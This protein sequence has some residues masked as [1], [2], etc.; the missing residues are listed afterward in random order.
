[1]K[2]EAGQ[3]QPTTDT[4]SFPRKRML[5]R[6]EVG[7]VVEMCHAGRVCTPSKVP[8]VH[9][10]MHSLPQLP[11]GTCDLPKSST[12]VSQQSLGNHLVCVTYD[13]PMRLLI[14][15]PS[16]GITFLRKCLQLMSFLPHF[17]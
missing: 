15:G 1:M 3:E 12:R 2:D 8:C 11:Q 9:T 17:V 16:Q 6:R 10:P 14:L 4:E 7:R 5:L 13:L